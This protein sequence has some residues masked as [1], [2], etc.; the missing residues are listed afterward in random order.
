MNRAYRL[1]WSGSH[2]AFLPVPEFARSCGKAVTV[3]SVR[4][5]GAIVLATLSCVAYALPTGGQISAGQGA[6]A[7]NG[8]DMTVTQRSQN[9]AINWQ[10]FG[11]GASESVTFAQPNASA[12]ALNRVLGADPTQIYGKLSANGQVWLLNP[13]GVLFG[14]GA[15]VNVGGLVASTLNISDAD[16]L[17]GKRTFNGTGGSVVNQGN[18]TAA[19]GGYVAM[20][21]GKVSN[22]G[23]IQARLG[24]VA[25]GAGKQVTLDFAGDKLLNLQVDQGAIDALVQ[26]KQL[27]QADGGTV[28]L[29]VRAANALLNTVVNNTGVIEARTI[30][31][32]GGTILLVGGSEGGTVNVSGTL[33][34]SAPSG[35]NGGVIETSGSQVKVADGAVITTA[36]AF[37]TAGTWLIDP[38][39]FTIAASGGDINGTTLASELN[40]TNVTI[41]S[42]SGALPGIGDINVDDTV[43]WNSSNSLTLSALHSVNVSQSISNAGSG[44][45]TLHADNRGACVA[46]ASNC[47][48]VTF[49]DP[50]HVSLN[51]GAL[52]IYYN[53]VGSNAAADANGNG[54]SYATPTDYSGNV[55]LNGG[56]TL[57]AW[58]LVNDVNQLQA[59]NTN[60]SGHYAL[61]N[62]VDAGGTYKWNGG[63]GF[64]PLGFDDNLNVFS[65]QFDGG[66]HVISSLTINRPTT[67]FV[68]MFG[69][70]SGSIANVGLSNVS[71]RGNDAVGGLV[72]QNN[73]GAISSSY[74]TGSVS[75]GSDVGGLVGSSQRDFT[76]LPPTPPRMGLISN[77]HF[78]GSVSGSS[79]VGGLVGGGVS[80][81]NNSYAAGQVSGGSNVGGLVGIVAGSNQYSGHDGGLISNSHFAGSVSG[82]SNVGGLVGAGMYH[83]ISN[84]HV[85]GQV[86]GANY[87]GGLVGSVAYLTLSNSHFV[88]SVSGTNY[89]GGLVGS[90][91]FTTISS[92]YFVGR[93]TGDSDVGGLV[94]SSYFSR[95]TRSHVIG[96]ISGGYSVGGL[97]GIDSGSEISKS[98]ATGH[99]TGN[100]N[101]GGLVGYNDAGAVIADS[102]SMGTVS[103]TGSNVGGLVGW[104]NGVIR[105]SDATGAIS[106]KSDVGGLVGHMAG[107]TIDGSHATGKV[108]AEWNFGGLVGWNS[109]PITNSYATGNLSGPIDVANIMGG[110][111]GENHASITDSHATG[112]VLGSSTTG[113]LV[114]SNY[115]GATI[116]RS[117]ATGTVQGRASGGLVGGNSADIVDSYATGNVGG[118]AGSG[119][120]VGFNAGN[121]VRSY[122]TGDVNASALGGGLVGSSSGSISASHATGNVNGGDAIGGLVGSNGGTVQDSYATGNVTSRGG[123][124]YGVGHGDEVGGLIGINAGSVTRSYATGNVSSLYGSSVGG[125]VGLNTAGESHPTPTGVQAQPGKISDSYATGNVSGVD[126]VGGLVGNN[127]AESFVI[128]AITTSF[129]PSITTSYS[130]GTVS[131][132]GN[133]GGLVGTNTGKVTN[134]YWDITTSGQTTSAGGV[135][136][137]DRQMKQRASFVGFDFQNVWRINQGHGYPQL[138]AISISSHPGENRHQDR[139]N[140]HDH[141][142]GHRNDAI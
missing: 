109:A 26:N 55:T 30:D 94:G 66:G 40:T 122:A 106:G 115:T 46:G 90:S 93:V 105:N 63:A 23:V 116:T 29:S 95:I 43:A 75:G 140:D 77:S 38:T 36:A 17:A 129:I 21:G 82:D 138:R 126:S 42:S 73:L 76:T 53:P 37:G 47:G 98:Y 113:G 117:Y 68:G 39:D 125:V 27:I 72:G 67:T 28:L 104:G 81:I 12:I 137:T 52:N 31:T 65:G 141:H 119:G 114:G 142:R 57:S 59:I 84:S 13:N 19:D 14:G 127:L 20:L 51:G 101:V 108:T 128:G 135:G 87:V 5:L 86:S 54:P 91:G 49:T 62:N 61:G 121:I 124:P 107:G 50:G 136:L 3:R 9:L 102:H 83:L 120:L 79:N 99:V 8:A 130:V 103:G 11:I 16:F 60:L 89:V 34:A 132:G 24:T 100:S 69:V 32:H 139:H 35:G 85:T 133:V 111:V 15:Q 70:S 4:S 10:S 71:I 96:R 97:I 48:T 25:L 74:V 6:I 80:D 58:M 2:C 1:V 56:S 78:R 92:S 33:D 118:E 45:V 7:A 112:N 134:S 110:L 64:V 41:R 22:E 18:I 123:S 88:G 44:G 131:G